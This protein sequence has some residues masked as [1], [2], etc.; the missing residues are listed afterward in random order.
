M[1]GFGRAESAE[2]PWAFT[3]EVQSVNHR[4]LEVRARLPRRWS[5]LEPR[6][7]QAVQQRFARGHFEVKLEERSQEGSRSLRVDLDLARQYV[8]ALRTLQRSLG[9]PGEITLEMLAGQRDLVAVDEA[10][11]NLDQ[12]WEALEP[13]LAA[14]L[15]EL[16]GMRAREGQALMEA[17]GRHLAEV[18]EGLQRVVARAPEVVAAQ[19]DRLRERVR[20][21][22]DGRLPDPERLEQEVALLAERADVAEECD[23]LRSHLAQF[24]RALQEAGPQGRRLDFLL[25]EIN[26]EVNTIGS[27]AA[28]A[29]IAQEVV[30][31]KSSVERLREQVQN[32]E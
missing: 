26:R 17:L 15:A 3:V 32:V 11:E 27:K 31:L 25:Q 8:E 6:V 5:G 1:T 10:A 2:P 20:E 21:L 13:V 16:A 14:A 30:G 12:I 18:D 29:A 7:Q 24:R 28:D 9:L 19:R 23:R 4:F 22:L